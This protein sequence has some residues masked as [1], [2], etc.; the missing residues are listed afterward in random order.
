MFA[1]GYGYLRL[2]SFEAGVLF[3]VP[4]AWG[5]AV[6]I[7]GRGGYCFVCPADRNT[8]FELPWPLG[9]EWLAI[10]GS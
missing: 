10:D 6:V 9:V 5:F 8:D 4:E 7:D 1:R 2:P 3:V